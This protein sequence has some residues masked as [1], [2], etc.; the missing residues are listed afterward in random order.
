IKTALANMFEAL[1]PGGVYVLDTFSRSPRA[2]LP[3]LGAS[4]RVYL[5]AP[6]RFEALAREVGFVVAERQPCYV[7]S[8]LIYRFLPFPLV[9][10]LDRVEPSLPPD[11]LARVFWKLE[12]P[13]QAG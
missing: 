13:A 1:K 2:W 4:G 8:P 12:K 3:F 9:Q 11:W 6:D 5:H 10:A 7:F